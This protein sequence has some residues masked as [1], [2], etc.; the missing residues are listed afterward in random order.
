MRHYF[1][2]IIFILLISSCNESDIYNKLDNTTHLENDSISRM[3]FHTLSNYKEV[4][5]TNLHLDLEINFDSK[6]IYGSVIHTI[7]NKNK[8]DSIIFDTKNLEIIEVSINDKKADYYLGEIDDLLGVP[9]IVQITEDTKEIK[10]EYSTTD[11]TEALDWLLPKQT[12]GKQVPF[13]YTQ[14]QSIFT[15]S[16]IPI[17]DTPGIRITYSAKIKTPDNM[18]AV[19]SASNPVKK[20]SSNI[21]NFSMPQ[22]IP[23][24]LIALAV[25]DLE[26]VEIDERTGVYTEPSMMEDCK[27]EFADM[28]KMVDVAEDIFG[29]YLWDRFDVIVLPPSFP[30]GGMENPRLTFATPTIIA[31]DRSLTSLIAHELA[32]SWS[33][34]LVTNA[35]WNDFWLN[36]GFTVYLERRIMEKLYGK[37]YSDML[38]LLG[39]Q[40]LEQ[41]ILKLEPKMQFLKLKLRNIHPDEAMSDIAYEKGYFLLRLIEETIGRDKTDPFFSKY[42]QDHSFQTLVTEEFIVY[43]EK[44][45]LQPNNTSLNLDAWIYNAGLPDNCPKIE[46]VLFNKVDKVLSNFYLTGNMN[47]IETDLWSTHEY[48]HFIRGLADSTSIDQMSIIDNKLNFTS[49]GNSEI[50]CAWF[51]KSI[52]FGYNEIDANL[53]KF[54]IRIGRRKFLQPLYIALA[55]TPEDKQKA[56]KIYKQARDN[57]H[58]ISS[59]TVDR[60]LEFVE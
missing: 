39:K 49:S 55:S 45:L 47:S 36:E 15:R 38:A 48:L 58:Y 41:T 56:I 7:N 35:T 10:I 40:D 18:L 21:Y 32:H 5:T 57:Y 37:D 11:K 12:A 24:Y 13:V 2:L 23:C 4:F 33:G 9:L 1:I 50:A 44:N 28:H 42:F 29:K 27:Y 26:F 60:I 16:W 17:Q 14:G 43:L 8:I 34:N 52:Y 31:G 22:A 19:M 30:F 54:L 46:S 59:N 53:E 6:K 51:E 20:D 3:D 25:G